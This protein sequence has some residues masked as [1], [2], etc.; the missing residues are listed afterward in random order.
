MASEPL[1][2][3]IDDNPE[4]LRLAEEVKETGESRVLRGHNE[5]LVLVTPIAG[6]QKRKGRN[7]LPPKTKEQ[8]EAFR[9]AA[10]AWKN[11]DTDAMKKYIYEGRTSSKPPV[12]L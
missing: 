11:V 8:V 4:L 3:N 6:K 5:D 1:P 12:D 2:M 7:T 10:G 9:S